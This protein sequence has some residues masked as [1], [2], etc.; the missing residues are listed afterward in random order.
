MTQ[1]RGRVA[2]VRVEAPVERTMGPRAHPPDRR[3]RAVLGSALLGLLLAAL[4]TPASA[5]GIHAAL[6][7]ASQTVD[8]GDTVY[9]ELWVTEAGLAFNGYDAVIGFD[10]GALTF[11][12]TSPLSL[13]EGSYM[14]SAC[15]S[16]FHYFVPAPDSLTISHAL[17]CAGKS[18]SGP[19]QLYKLRF[20]ASSTVQSTSVHIRHIQF[21][22]AGVY[23]NP[24][25]A[26]DAVVGIGIQAGVPPGGP[27]AGAV[28]LRALPNP[29]RSHTSLAVDGGA[30]VGPLVLYDLAGRRVRTLDGALDDGDT[31]R[32]EWDGRDA[33]G[34]ALAPGVYLA[35]IHVATSPVSARVVLLP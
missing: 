11:L 10:S 27:G 18:L 21:Y 25:Y 6:L 29:C 24:A 15:G 19:G 14:K 3:M 31:W 9:V 23:V 1:V 20:R 26:S 7:P 32:F 22:D 30:A 28:R 16:T 4:A 35:V 5:D 8:P 12:P 17:L 33:A 2:G 13:Q 34:T